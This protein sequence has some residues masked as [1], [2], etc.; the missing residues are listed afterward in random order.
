[1]SYI[2]Q[3]TSDYKREAKNKEARQRIRGERKGIF[4]GYIHLYCK[5]LYIHCDSF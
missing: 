4:G 2:P 1:M 5:T 3:I